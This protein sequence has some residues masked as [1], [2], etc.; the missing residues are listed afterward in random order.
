MAED[1]NLSHLQRVTRIM[2]PAAA[3][4]EV[5]PFLAAVTVLAVL[6]AFLVWAT[7]S[8]LLHN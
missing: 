3:R 4:S 7:F 6:P 5:T 8:P 1:G 2:V